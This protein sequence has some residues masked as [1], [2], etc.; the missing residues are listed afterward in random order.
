MLPARRRASLAAALVAAVALGPL[1]VAPALATPRASAGVTSASTAAV[2]TASIDGLLAVG[3]TVSV[4]TDGWPEGTELS[5]QWAAD[6][7]VLDGATGSSL[8]IDATLEGALLSVEV[9]GPAPDETEPVVVTAAAPVRVALAG[10]PV[11]KGTASVGATLTA[12]P[13][14]WTAGTAYTYQWFA[15]GAAISGA[16]SAI[17]APTAT[18]AGKAITVRVT[19]TKAGHQTVVRTSAP[20]LR[21]MKWATPTITGTAVSGS[22]LTAAPGAWTT[23]ATLGYQWF[24]DGAA[25]SGATSSTF[26]PGNGQSGKKITVKVT[27]R[28]DGHTSVAKVSAATLKVMLAPTPKI[29]GTPV[30]GRTLTAAPG[31]WTTGTTLTYRWYADGTAI[32]GATGKTYTVPTS[33]KGKKLVVKVTGKK[34]GHPTVTRASAATAAVTLPPVPTAPVPTVSGTAVAGSTLTAKP[35]TWTSGTTLSYRWYADGAAISGAT[36]KTYKVPTT[37]RDKRITVKVTGKKTGYANVTKTSA[38]TA[39]VQVA[40]TP[41]ISGT[42]KVTYTL[43]ANRGSGWSSGTAFTYQWY[44]NGK[45]IS[46]ATSSSLKLSASR[47]GQTITV[48][49][50]GKKSGYPTVSRTSRATAAVTYPT[51]TAP[52]SS[53]NCPSWAP[54]KGNAN[55][56]I[57]HMPYQRYYDATKPEDCFRTEA[58]AVAAGYRKAKV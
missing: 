34:T 44:A 1:A 50:T 47:A 19:G 6:Q 8:T 20:S 56:G 42:P 15:D 33:M 58:A 2:S 12:Q 30:A 14:A 52:I 29:S 43:K 45:A 22:T 54:I 27:G 16:T 38:A 48:K 49:V 35:G 26:K 25:I 21:V 39:R 57:Y 18:Q 5:Y 31:T 10:T 4:L 41:T 9:T 46:G 37:M 51:R 13:G 32:S 28:K 24:A 55:S 23:G 40:P 11:V 36:G 3:E 53:W 7:A 17:Y